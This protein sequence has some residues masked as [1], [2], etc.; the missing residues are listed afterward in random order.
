[1]VSPFSFTM[2]HCI[3]RNFSGESRSS[4]TLSPPPLIY[5]A[6]TFDASFQHVTAERRWHYSTFRKND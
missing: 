4:I 5:R 2:L 3:N 1:M 6:R